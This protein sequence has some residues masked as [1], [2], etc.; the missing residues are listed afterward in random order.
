VVSSFARLLQ[1]HRFPEFQYG[2]QMQHFEYAVEWDVLASCQEMNRCFLV[3]GLMEGFAQSWNDKPQFS[4]SDLMQ[5]HADVSRDH[6]PT[7]RTR[8][9]WR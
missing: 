3:E 6:E 5:M 1:Y 9:D 8:F 2:D 4:Q 7:L